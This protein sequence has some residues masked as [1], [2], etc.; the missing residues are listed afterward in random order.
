MFLVVFCTLISFLSAEPIVQ[1]GTRNISAKIIILLFACS[2]LGLAVS[3]HHLLACFLGLELFGLSTRS[4][5][6]EHG[7][8]WKSGE[9]LL[10]SFITNSMSSGIFLLG[11]GFIFSAFGTLDLNQINNLVIS[12]TQ[13][14]LPSLGVAFILVGL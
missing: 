9:A 7:G 1:R 3:T 13:T 11:I 6:Y 10:K 4:L 2:G 12:P 14:F 8:S 5:L